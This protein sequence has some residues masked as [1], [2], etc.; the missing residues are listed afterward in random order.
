MVLLLTPCFMPAFQDGSDGTNHWLRIVRQELGGPADFFLDLQST[1]ECEHLVRLCAQF[2]TPVL[3]IGH[4]SNI[5]FLDQG[6]RGIVARMG[7]KTIYLEEPTGKGALA[8][9]EAGCTWVELIEEVAQHGWGGLDFGREIPGTVGGAIVTNAGFHNEAI[10]QYVQWVE[11]LDARGCNAEEEGEWAVPQ[12]RRYTQADLQLSNRQSRFRE[13]RRAHIT[14]SGQLVPAPR[15]LIAPPEIILRLGVRVPRTKGQPP[16]PRQPDERGGRKRQIEAFAGHVGP[17]FQDPIGEKASQLIAQGGRDAWRKG[18]VQVSAYDA[19]FLVN[20]GGAQ[21]A[22]IARM[23]V[24]IHQQVLTQTG[25]DLA[26]DL[27]LYDA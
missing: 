5:L 22:D 6:V 19:N 1:T 20:R 18:V 4:G 3:I 7:A 11:V 16:V 13:Q 9:V 10:G 21:A 26:V 2:R 15:P 8:V 23:I 14:A 17:L 25:I 27:E 12:V 24:A